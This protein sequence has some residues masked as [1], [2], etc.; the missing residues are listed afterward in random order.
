MT[1]EE[2][3]GSSRGGDIR[4]AAPPLHARTLGQVAQLHFLLL[5][6]PGLQLTSHTIPGLN[7][8]SPDTTS[9]RRINVGFSIFTG[10]RVLGSQ[11][12]VHTQGCIEQTASGRT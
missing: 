2:L 1:D 4:A 9:T 12:Y 5:L 7:C 10:I 3:P 11:R 6:L 8:K